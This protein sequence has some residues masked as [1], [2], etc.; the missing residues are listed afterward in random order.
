MHGISYPYLKKVRV[1]GS[2]GLQ[3]PPRLDE[4]SELVYY[5]E[6]LSRPVK[7]RQNSWIDVDGVSAWSYQISDFNSDPAQEEIQNYHTEYKG[8][9][10]TSS[11]FGIPLIVSKS[12]F[13]GVDFKDLKKPTFE[14]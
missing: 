1:N 3:F 14:T 9:F 5:N 2:D 7:L 12:T 13:E 8:T 4:E 11:V 10:N 6:R